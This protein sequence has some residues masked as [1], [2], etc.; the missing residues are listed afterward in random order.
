MKTM[1]FHAQDVTP[2]VKEAALMELW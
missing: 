2:R 1:Q